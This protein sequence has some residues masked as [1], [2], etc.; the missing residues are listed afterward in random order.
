MLYLTIQ[1]AFILH[2]DHLPSDSGLPVGVTALLNIVFDPISYHVS[3]IFVTFAQIK[4]G[5]NKN[6]PLAL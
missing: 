4:I 6:F 3:K 1:N 2:C 5:H